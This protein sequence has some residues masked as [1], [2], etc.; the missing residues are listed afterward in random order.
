MNSSVDFNKL[1]KTKQTVKTGG[2]VSYYL[3]ELTNGT[4]VE[5]DDINRVMELSFD[6]GTTL[7]SL[8]RLCKN[9][10]KLGKP[11]SDDDYEIGKVVYYTKETDSFTQD[12]EAEISFI[13]KVFRKFRDPFLNHH[14]DINNVEIAILKPK[15]LPP[16]SF[17][18]GDFIDAHNPTEEERLIFENTFKLIV[19]RLI[20]GPPH[21]DEME[22]TA[23]GVSLAKLLGKPR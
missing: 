10:M 9:R 19:L 1:A 7:K 14:K 21:R 16:Y 20:K 22:L 4:V 13:G 5:N 23:K 2:D 8:T 11:G 12:R 17:R 3:T 18:V 6:M 15:R